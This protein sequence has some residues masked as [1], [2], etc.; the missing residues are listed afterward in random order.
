[1]YAYILC[2]VKAEHGCEVKVPLGD[3]HAQKKLF[4]HKDHVL[5]S[6]PCRSAV[7]DEHQGGP[8]W[9]S[10]LVVVEEAQSQSREAPLAPCGCPWA[11]WSGAWA[12]GRQRQHGCWVSLERARPV[13]RP[14]LVPVLYQSEREGAAPDP[15]S[16]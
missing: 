3:R 15:E 6:S 11:C 2:C 12:E 16:A 13:L 10:W 7:L 4:S 5:V 1:M 9:P 8:A 14:Q